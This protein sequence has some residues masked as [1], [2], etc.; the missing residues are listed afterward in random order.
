MEGDLVFTFRILKVFKQPGN[1]QLM[2]LF[3]TAR[4][5]EASCNFQ[6]SPSLR[7]SM[8]SAVSAHA[9][10]ELEITQ[11]RAQEQRVE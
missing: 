7:L 5:A 4:E 8:T 9:Q 3:L 6:E 1:Q 2:F 11:C 10:G